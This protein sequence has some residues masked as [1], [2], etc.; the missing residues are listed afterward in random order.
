MMPI[1]EIKNALEICLEIRRETDGA[2]LVS[3]GTAES[4]FIPKSEIAIDG[5]GSEG[6][7]DTVVF[8]MPEWLA[9]KKNFV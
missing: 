4:V 7:G 9:I 8:V 1:D 2:Y 5:D 3:D 6:A